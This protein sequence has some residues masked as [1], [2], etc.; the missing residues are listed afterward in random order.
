LLDKLR[1]IEAT[2]RAMD[3]VEARCLQ[4]LEAGRLARAG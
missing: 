2:L 3:E 1:D 4:E